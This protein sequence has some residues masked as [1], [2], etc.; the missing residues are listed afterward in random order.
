MT[1]TH[2]T[3]P[4]KAKA[5]A[6]ISM[7][8]RTKKELGLS[9]KEFGPYLYTSKDKIGRWLRGTSLPSS[10]QIDAII[11]L[12]DDVLRQEAQDFQREADIR[13]GLISLPF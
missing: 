4:T 8:K 5:K 2:I 3:P 10:E 13:Y 7:L 12:H 11:S 6:F 1:A 9:N